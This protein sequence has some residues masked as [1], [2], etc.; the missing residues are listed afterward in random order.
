MLTT[1]LEHLATVL[2]AFAAFVAALASWRTAKRGEQHLQEIKISINGRLAELMA[3]ATAAATTAATTA[4]ATAAALA[5]IVIQ[6][7]HT[8]EGRGSKD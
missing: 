5:K 6:T 2:T 8:S 3:T 1:G 7:A 4:A